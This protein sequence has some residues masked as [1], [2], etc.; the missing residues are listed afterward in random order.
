MA[1][2]PSLSKS[3]TGKGDTVR[4]VKTN[5]HPKL[6]LAK[7]RWGTFNGDSC[8]SKLGQSPF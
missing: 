5:M 6:T 3:S 8:A 2:S 7:G 4:F 1:A